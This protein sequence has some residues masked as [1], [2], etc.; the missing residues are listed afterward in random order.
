MNMEQSLVFIKP[1]ITCQGEAKTQE[2]FRYLDLLLKNRYSVN[3]EYM[4]MGKIIPSRE[5]ID[6]HYSDVRPK[7]SIERYEEMVK[8]FT[9]GFVE[10]RIY[11]SDEKIIEPLLLAIGKTD[12]AACEWWQVRAKYSKDSIAQS[13]REKRVVRNVI[14]RSGSIKE[15]EFELNLW[16]DFVRTK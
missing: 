12:P 13:E 2:V 6:K 15:A 8:M 3:F 10:G 4:P 16:L 9:G 5:L 1:D 7:I 14:H 11:H